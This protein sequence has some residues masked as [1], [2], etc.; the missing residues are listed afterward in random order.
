M[1]NCIQGVIYDLDGVIVNTA[2]LHLESWKE[3]A[4]TLHIRMT[5]E[6]ALAQRGV[7]RRTS[8][9]I[10]LEANGINYL[11]ETELQ[12]L[13]NKK[14]EYYLDKIRGLG[15]QD[16]LDGALEALVESKRLGLKI[17]LGSASRNAPLV[18]KQLG[19][20]SYFDFVVNPKDLRSKPEPD[21]FIR[22]AEGIGIAPHN[23]LVF[24]DS[25]SGILA[26]QKAQMKFVAIG[27]PSDFKEI[28][29]QHCI[30]NLSY[31]DFERMRPRTVDANIGG[32]LKYVEYSKTT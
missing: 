11:N 21:I 15:K 22:A 5:E 4:K 1:S 25:I 7:D 6:I 30:P 16:L 31:W 24:E 10:L 19:I 13:M 2:Q 14:N 26:A 8:L 9:K 28:K 3:L 32:S 23:C 18:L 29:L 27:V 20:E 12:Q 17:G